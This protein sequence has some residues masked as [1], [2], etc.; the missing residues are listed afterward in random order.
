MDGHN[1]VIQNPRLPQEAIL[2]IDP[3]NIMPIFISVLLSDKAVSKNT[4]SCFLISFEK[5]FVLIFLD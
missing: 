4:A 1:A 3:T 2:A 5:T